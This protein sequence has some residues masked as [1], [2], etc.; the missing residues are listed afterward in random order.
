VKIA[1]TTNTTIG[2]PLAIKQEV[3]QNR[4]DKSGVYQLTCPESKMKYTG[5]TGRPFKVRFQEHAWTLNT[6]TTDL[7]SP[8]TL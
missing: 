6:K 2:K 8:N 3:P 7:N 5:Q 1:F 4:Y